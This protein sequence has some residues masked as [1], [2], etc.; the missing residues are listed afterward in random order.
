MVPVHSAVLQAVPVAV[1]LLQFHL[2]VWH[3]LERLEHPAAAAVPQPWLCL[4]TLQ[5]AESGGQ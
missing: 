5:P 2:F 4:W 1:D 3:Q